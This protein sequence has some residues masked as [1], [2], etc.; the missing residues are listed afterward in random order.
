LLVG[1]AALARHAHAQ[2]GITFMLDNIAITSDGSNSFY[3][4]DIFVQAASEGTALGPSLVLLN[5]NTAG[6]GSSVDANGRVTVTEGSYTSSNSNYGIVVN[7]NTSSTVAITGTYNVFDP[8]NGEPLPTTP[9]QLFHVSM[10]ILDPA[11]AAGIS[12]RVSDME[13][14]QFEDDLA[15]TYTPVLAADSDDTVLPVELVAFEARLDG[16]AAILEWQTASET[17]NAGFEVEVQRVAGAERPFGAK[18][19]TTWQRLAWVDGQGTTTEAQAYSYRVASLEPG[20]H[21]F[22]LKQIDYDGT[23]AYSPEVEVTAEVPGAYLMSAAYPNPFNP[24]T[25]FTLA[26][27]RAQQV[28]VAVYDMLGREVVVL[29]RGDMLAHETQSFQWQAGGHAS[30]LYFIRVVGETFAQTRR[31]TLVK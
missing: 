5:Y 1:S 24:Q 8:D 26:V 25:Q 18:A 12:F 6:F 13:G 15:T 17:N 9:V 7:D 11:E 31:V 20:Q 14:Q 21:V 29:F 4:F 27:A 16:A 22:R 28:T 3:E 19:D 10:Q 30:G 23:F 2:M